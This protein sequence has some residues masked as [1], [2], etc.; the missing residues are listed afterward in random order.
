MYTFYHADKI[1]CRFP[2]EWYVGRHLCFLTQNLL[3]PLFQYRHQSIFCYVLSEAKNYLQLHFTASWKQLLT[4][5]SQ[6]DFQFAL[7]I[8]ITDVNIPTWDD[9][10]IPPTVVLVLVSAFS[11]FSFTQSCYSIVQTAK[12]AR[13]KCWTIEICT[14]IGISKSIQPDT[15]TNKMNPHYSMCWKCFTFLYIIDP[16]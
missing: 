3:T 9:C 14:D 16:L 7:F 2:V 15:F 13:W 12:L 11:M 4:S 8:F 6:P 5:S 1:T 10:C